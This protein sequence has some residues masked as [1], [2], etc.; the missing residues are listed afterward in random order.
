MQLEKYGL[1]EIQRKYT[2]YSK[3]GN[4]IVRCVCKCECGNIIEADF[5]H[6]KAGNIKTCKCQKKLLGKKHALW[7]GYGDIPLTYFNNIKNKSVIRNICF[8]VTIEDFWNQYVKQNG[9]CALTKTPIDFIYTS[10]KYRDFSAS[11]DRIDSSKG[12][13]IDNIQWVHKKINMMKGSLQDQEF[14]EWCS[15]VAL[16]AEGQ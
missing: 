4:A 10:N 8:D 7:R 13:L 1:L 16:A 14:I 12:Y 3:G 15:K 5:K 11:L 2:R 6:L 9:L